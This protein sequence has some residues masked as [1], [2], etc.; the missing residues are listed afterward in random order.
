M[1]EEFLSLGSR[2]TMTANSRETFDPAFLAASVRDLAIEARRILNDSA[3]NP[4]EVGALS[5]RITDLQSQVPN[6][7]PS[8]LSRWLENL[9]REVGSDPRKDQRVTV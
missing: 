9:S 3:R 5:R 4:F 7:T 1:D 2:A 6:R 8:E